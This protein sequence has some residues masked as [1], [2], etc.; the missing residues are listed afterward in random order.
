MTTTPQDEDPVATLLQRGV[1][2]ATASV[3]TYVV[4]GTMTQS[5]AIR[6]VPD[7]LSLRCE[8]PACMREMMWQRTDRPVVQLDPEH[9]FVG[10]LKNI[11][12]KCRNCQRAS[13]TFILHA[14]RLE[15]DDQATVQIVGRVPKASPTMPD[16]LR[17]ALSGRTVDQSLYANALSDR[18]DGQ[19]IGAMTY[20]RRVV[21]NEMNALLDLLITNLTGAGDEAR[22]RAL[23]EAKRL[24]GEYS[25]TE[26]AHAADTVLPETFFPGNQNPF[27]RLHD[28]CSDGVHNLDDVESCER[29]DDANEVFELLFIRL[30]QMAA[31][32]RVYEEKL[33]KLR[34]RKS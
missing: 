31:T 23:E 11:T 3:P 5:R 28:L 27:M 29:F 34:G 12:Y 25:F 24:E 1:L 9:F 7:T 30:L 20:L 15:G 21:E 13:V 2:Y 10:H 32:K 17:R 33:K 14:L 8:S 22:L 6:G 16:E 18:A 4:Q 26:K 19:G